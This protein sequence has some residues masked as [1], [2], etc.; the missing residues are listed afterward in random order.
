MW[1]WFIGL[2]LITQGIYDLSLTGALRMAF[3][4]SLSDGST[5]R[6][7]AL[8]CHCTHCPDLRTCCCLPNPQA[9][10]TTVVSQCDP[11]P[12]EKAVSTW[13]FR[14]ASQLLPSIALAFC[15]E[16]PL[17]YITAYHEGCSSLPDPPPR[18]ARVFNL[19]FAFPGTQNYFE[20]VKQCIE[21]GSP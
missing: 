10:V 7:H 16:E 9:K 3:G 13:S 1:R 18:S 17:L 2:V 12:G 4:Q 5:E 20:E 6:L 8:Y 15:N 14:L 19:Y 11:S 21:K